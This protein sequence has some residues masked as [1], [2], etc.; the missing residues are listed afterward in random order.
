MKPYLSRGGARAENQMR[1]LLN[2]LLVYHH[3]RIIEILHQ[4]IDCFQLRSQSFEHT[5]FSYRIDIKPV[6]M[7]VVD[8]QKKILGFRFKAQ[9]PV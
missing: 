9:V 7:I 1:V 4:P 3:I 6:K 5:V 8:K 2:A